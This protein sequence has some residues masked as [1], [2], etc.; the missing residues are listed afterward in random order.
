MNS[1]ES[2]LNAFKTIE[3]N[4]KNKPQKKSKSQ[5]YWENAEFTKH[6]IEYICSLSSKSINEKIRFILKELI[7]ACS[8]CPESEYIEGEDEVLTL[9]NVKNF[10]GYGL[11]T[12][13]QYSKITDKIYTPYIPSFLKGY[14]SE[15][16]TCSKDFI[17]IFIK[18]RDSNT[19]EDIITR[20][21]NIN[22]NNPNR[23][24][25]LY[26]YFEFILN[27]FKQT[28]IGELSRDYSE[29]GRQ[30]FK[31]IKG[32]LQMIQNP[33]IKKAVNEQFNISEDGYR[34]LELM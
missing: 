31:R 30:K 9:Y 33:E 14:E 24:K 11:L 26:I 28:F 19:I 15:W 34:F 8:I 5:R 21:I 7:Y 32:Y 20:N 18:F 13:D 1:Y 12:I 27:R 16:D 22:I 10:K 3:N 4:L 25:W 23:Q 29:Q 17:N 6:E 2:I